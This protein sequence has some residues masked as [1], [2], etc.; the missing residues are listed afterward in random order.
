MKIR[1]DFVTNSS[2]SSFVAVTIT[3]TD[4]EEIHGSS[5]MGSGYH[6]I[7]ILDDYNGEEKTDTV[8]DIIDNSKNGI[9]FCQK[10]Y[11][12]LL[13]EVN[14]V[15]DNL[16]NVRDIDSFSYVET[17][18]IVAEQE[19]ACGGNVDYYY[20]LFD[21]KIS[22]QNGSN[23]WDF[24]DDFEE[25]LLEKS[26]DLIDTFNEDGD[27]EI[28]NGVLKK[29][30]GNEKVVTVPNGVIGIGLNAFFYSFME[31]II[32]PAGVK[33][34]DCRAFSNCTKLKKINIPFGVQ[35]IGARA[36]ENCHSLETI[37]IPDSVVG[38]GY[39]CFCNAQG[40][41]EV[42][43]SDAISMMSSGL[44]YDCSNLEKIRLPKNVFIIRD[45][46]FMGCRSLK[47]M[48]IPEGVIY[49]GNNVFWDCTN[50]EKVF[51]PST[52]ETFYAAQF[53][54][55]SNLKE[56]EI[57]KDNKLFVNVDGGIYTRDMRRLIKVV[58]TSK[59]F[60]VKEGTVYV[61]EYAFS[62]CETVEQVYLPSTLKSIGIQAFYN[63]S[64]LKEIDL[65]SSLVSLSTDAFAY[66]PSLTKAYVPETLNCDV[67][68]CFYNCNENLEI[69][70]K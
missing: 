13:F 67:S 65:P 33:F 49:L 19:G 42:K 70:F 63:C 1:T 4:G 59:E 57:D 25:E 31:E 34:I 2:S 18:H 51:L 55:C 20:D 69:T 28:K 41:K 40:L 62:K 39:K 45:E 36:F 3:T 48:K 61:G 68:E 6:Q 22:K 30:N 66:C 54:Y 24:Y 12:E 23:D 56:I 26:F 35:N 53:S 60:T 37:D 15:H 44:F 17:V 43:M 7:P 16:Y 29:Y 9:E 5:N 32:L 58:T 46:V 8:K 38:L 64:S 11:E 10:L 50:L 52:L 47:E 27:F 14:S 21:G